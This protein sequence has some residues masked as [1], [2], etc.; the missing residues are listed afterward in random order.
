M[1][2]SC[3]YNLKMESVARLFNKECY[4]A[5]GI[6]AAVDPE[7]FATSSWYLKGVSNAY[8]LSFE[9]GEGGVSYTNYTQHFFVSIIMKNSTL[10][11]SV[12]CCRLLEPHLMRFKLILP[13]SQ[14]QPP[15]P[16]P[17]LCS[18]VLTELSLR[19]FTAASQQHPLLETRML[20]HVNP[21]RR[22]NMCFSVLHRNCASC[23]TP[24]SLL[25]FSSLLL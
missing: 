22:A 16:P 24:S 6:T 18:T 11:T 19:P 21:Y 15:P 10:C 4:W 8:I 2:S 7:T 13:Q 1:F 23:W 14:I 17:L 12:Q 9:I 5:S 25:T 3:Y 20:M